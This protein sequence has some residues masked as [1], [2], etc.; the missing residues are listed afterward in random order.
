MKWKLMKS[1]NKYIWEGACLLL[2]DRR[3]KKDVEVKFL[4]QTTHF[5]D[6]LEQVL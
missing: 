5:D 4:L 3:K 1:L 6:E 2:K